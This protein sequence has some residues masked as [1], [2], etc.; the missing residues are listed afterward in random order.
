M[1]KLLEETPLEEPEIRKRIL[2]KT[3]EDITT[4]AQEKLT[5]RGHVRSGELLADVGIKEITDDYV[6][7]GT[8]VMQAFFIE[9]GRGEVRPINAKVLHF[10]AKDG[11]EVFTKFSKAVPAQPFLESSVIK[12]TKNTGNLYA[13]KL[14]QTMQKK[15]TFTRDD[16]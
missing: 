6:V 13:E 16:V 14:E 2:I 11:T 4:E 12:N 10:F 5:M 8:T 7:F 3:A 1:K 9:F 15:L